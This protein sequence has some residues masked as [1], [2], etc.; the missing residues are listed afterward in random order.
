MHQVGFSQ[1][2][3][4]VDEQGIIFVARHLGRQLCGGTGQTIALSY[5]EGIKGIPRIEL[6]AASVGSRRL[7]PGFLDGKHRGKIPPAGGH[8]CA[9][10]EIIVFHALTEKEVKSIVNIMLR[11]LAKQVKEQMNIELKYTETLKSALAKESYDK[12]YGARP[13]RRMIQN[14][15]ED[16]LAEE[17]LAEKVKQGD[18]V[19]VSYKNKSVTFSVAE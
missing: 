3:A 18:K 10:D 15:I 9:F 2:C 16:N 12:K 11:N 17:I 7:H 4:A 13:L 5:H 19:T 1:P 8:Q 6:Q 14:K